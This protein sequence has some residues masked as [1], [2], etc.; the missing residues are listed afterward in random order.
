[1]DPYAKIVTGMVLLIALPTI[2]TGVMYFVFPTHSDKVL[3]LAFGACLLGES[4]VLVYAIGRK[5]FR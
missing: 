2:M 4:I 5:I 1:M 3:G